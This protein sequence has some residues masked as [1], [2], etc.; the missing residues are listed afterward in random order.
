MCDVNIATGEVTRFEFDILLAGRIPWQLNRRYSSGNPQLSLV[1]FGWK[2][3]LGT[4]LRRTGAEMEMFVDGKPYARL[5]LLLIGERR[6]VNEAGLVAERINEGILVTDRSGSTHAFPCQEQLPNVIQCA[7]RY[8]HYRNSVE[9]H[10]DDKERLR[11]LTDTFDR[12]ICFDYDLRSRLVEVYV[13]PVD[14][15]STRWSLVRYEYDDQDDL[16]TVVDANGNLTRYEYSAHLLTRSTDRSGRD[17]YFQYDQHQRCVRT[18]F[19]GGVWDRQLSYDPH[20]LRVLVTHPDGFSKLFKQNEQGIVVGDIDPLGR[21]REDVLDANGLLL[22]RAGVGGGTQT[23][24]WRDAGSNTVMMSRNG[25][26]NIFEVNANDQVTL[27]KNPDGR[28]W[29]YD[30]DRAGNQTRSEDPEGGVWKFDYNEH[31]DLVRSVDPIG[32][33]R[34]RKR[35]PDR[36]TL[37]DAWGVRQDERFDRFGRLIAVI[38]GEGGEMRFELDASGKPL[39]RINPDGSSFA[40]EYDPSGRPTILTD[41]LGARFQVLRDAPETGITVVRPD[42]HE[43]VFEYGLMD[44]IRRITNANGE[45]A[46]FT[47]D[48]AGRC[49]AITYFN[50]GQHRFV[51]DDADNPIA[52]LDGRTGMVL[53]ECKY[54][55]DL[56][57]E[58]RYYDGRRLRIEYGQSGE[59]VSVENSDATLSYERDALKRLT[60]ARSNRLELHYAYNKRGDCT[61]LTAN[62]G[63]TIDYH[64]D[65]RRRLVRIVDSAS[66]TYEYSYDARDLVTEIRMPNGCAQHFEYDRRHRMISRRVT[67]TDGSE[68]SAREFSYDAC[69]RLTGY[70]DSLRGA[71]RYA[72]NVAGFVASFSDNG[73]VVRFEHDANGNLLTTRTGAAIAYATGDRATRVGADQLE[74]DDR[75][76]LALWRSRDGESRFEYTGEGYLKSAT[77]A[78]G[79]RAEY[80]Y[81][82]MARRIAKTVNGRRTE[83]DWD[84]VHLLAERRTGGEVIEYLFMPGSFFLTGITCGG[85]HYSCVCDQLGTPTELIDGAGEVAWAADYAPHGETTAVRIDKVSQPFRFVGQYFDE[86]LAWHYNRYRYYQPAV[87]RFTSPDPLGFAAGM[88]LYRYAPNPVN[89]ADPLGLSFAPPGMGPIYTCEVISRCDWGPKTM[90]EAQKKTDGVNEKGCDAIVTGPCDRPPDQKDYLMKNCVDEADKAKVEASLKS[91]GDSCKS[92]QVDHIKEVQCGGGNDCNNLAPLTQTVNGSFGSQIKG[93]RDQLAAQGVTGV[94]KMA[95]N[96]IDIRTASASQLK[97]HDR[98]PCEGNEGRCP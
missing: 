30:Y 8:D 83:F 55:D 69:G 6:P 20:R 3:N 45:T 23:V 59:V 64:W 31:G 91:Q 81:D 98:K 36:L 60:V 7:A 10:Y 22:F 1:G 63:R 74:Y 27:M 95:I 70:R 53:A 14:G 75:G 76:N 68:I 28:V 85:R 21:V 32:Y 33:E 61:S 12:Q 34:Y 82:G 71:R 65:G 97:N 87:G 42:G 67:R 29:K 11:T 26:K 51:Y 9:Y 78:D 62:T 80:E 77:L 35:S 52:L 86:E 46:D 38:D 4:F 25:S 24:I 5:P 57:A 41:E 92:Q 39:R 88:N 73:E 17:L 93:C 37:W 47:Y 49:I 54:E 66:G 72:Y 19:T 16:V 79:T 84:G 89:W 58:E 94:V 13:R 18:W 96:L 15:R 90:K 56:L 43:E 48:A 40:I 44:E 2:L 50:G